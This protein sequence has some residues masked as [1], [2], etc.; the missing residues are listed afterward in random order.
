[1]TLDMYLQNLCIL[2][3]CLRDEHG[4]LVWVISDFVQVEHNDHAKVSYDYDGQGYIVCHT[5]DQGGVTLNIDK[6]YPL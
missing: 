4:R 3:I 5:D 1:M 2:D 6:V